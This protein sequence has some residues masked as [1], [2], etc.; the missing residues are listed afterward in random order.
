M[1][2]LLEVTY[3]LENMTLV[4]SIPKLS[5]YAKILRVEKRLRP[6]LEVLL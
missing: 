5:E 4:P 1:P 3:S 6:Y 2:S